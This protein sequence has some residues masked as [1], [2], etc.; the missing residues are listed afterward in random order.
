MHSGAHIAVVEAVAGL[1]D[2]ADKAIALMDM[3]MLVLC[4]GKQ[5]TVEEFRS[6]MSEVGIELVGVS[7]AGLQSVVEGK[8]V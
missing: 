5:R 1:D 7:R 6:L 4:E 2:T 8:K 3:D